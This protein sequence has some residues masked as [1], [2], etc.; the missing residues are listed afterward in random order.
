MTAI[1]IYG[2]HGAHDTVL[3]N[4]VNATG[5]AMSVRDT[6]HTP[7]NKRFADESCWA[8]LC[9]G[10]SHEW[11]S[12][13]MEETERFKSGRTRTHVISLTMPRAVAEQ[14]AQH[15]LS[16]PRDLSKETR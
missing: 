16:G 14:L 10:N 13:Q 6:D 11:V 4:N 15:V 12:I 7:Y 5:T 9:V 3:T 2:P 8:T 1:K